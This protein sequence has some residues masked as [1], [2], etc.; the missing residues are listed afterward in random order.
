M[1]KF[2]KSLKIL[3]VILARGGSKGIPKKNIYEINNHPLISYSIT[4][5]LNSK[6]I[7]KIIVSSDS[8]KILNLS[9]EYGVDA[10]IKRPKKLASDRATSADALFHAVNEAEKIFKNKFKFIIEIPCVSPM[11][12]NI[13]IDKALKVI[14]TEKYDSVV[15][16]VD[17]GEKHPIRLKRIKNGKIT[18]FCKEYKEAS[19]GSIRQDFEPCFIRNGAIYAMTRDCI[20]KKKSRWGNKSYP[21]IMDALKSVNIDEYQD[22]IVAKL[23]IENG[24]CNN[25]PKKINKIEISKF[26][27]NKFTVLI[28]TP[29]TFL[30]DFRKKLKK[31]FNCIFAHGAGINE[32]KENLKKADYWICSPSPIYKIDKKCLNGSKKIKAIF[33]PS[34]GSTHI[35]KNYLKKRKIKLFTI[36]NHK[37]LKSIKASSEFTFGLVLDA[38]RNL[39]KGVKLAHTGHWRQQENLLRGN[40]LY[41]KKLGIIGFGRIGSNVYKYAK[42]FGMD[43]SSY[44]IN[45]NK[46]KYLKKIKIFNNLDRL[47]KHSD[48]ILVSV[49]LDNKSKNMI[50][51]NFLRKMKKDAILINTSRGEIINEKH[52]LSNLKK[53]KIKKAVVDVLQKE[54]RKN[55]SNNKMIN[56]SKFNN[57][58]II[59]PHMAGLTYES[60]NIAAEIIYKKLIRNLNQK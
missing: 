33:T 10:T 11:R 35:D 27:K 5:A 23:L 43:V 30:N 15:S 28:T 47:I 19:W 41:K 40:Q 1:I 38:F 6:Y 24:Y 55:F 31:G 52:L 49:H 4:A 13:D 8:D 26:D 21:L 25:L 39:S 51:N 29:I 20:L 58:L 56:Y 42:S 57:N 14:K 53:N 50:D 22:L 45:K 44:D 3:A 17:T 9:K 54:Q 12:D 59:T 18:N 34:T 32:I 48:A 46:V 7:D 36:R 16:Y 2:K 37:K 60:E